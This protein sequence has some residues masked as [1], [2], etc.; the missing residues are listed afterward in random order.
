MDIVLFCGI[1]QPKP[2]LHHLQQQHNRVESLFFPDH[3][4]FT[5]ANYKQIIQSFDKLQASNKILLTTEKDFQRIDGKCFKDLPLYY[6]P[7]RI[8]F[9]HPSKESFD[10]LV[11]DYVRETI[12]NH[13]IS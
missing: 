11:L 2:L 3:H 1:A 8:D 12:A 10:T 4:Y 13:Q 6:I 7:I 9:L 5:G